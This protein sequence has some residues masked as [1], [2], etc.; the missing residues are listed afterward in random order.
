V[1]LLPDTRRVGRPVPRSL[2]GH[3]NYNA[4]SQFGGDGS[5]SPVNVDD[6]GYTTNTFGS[7]GSEPSYTNATYIAGHGV[8]QGSHPS[9]FIGT[10]LSNPQRRTSRS[11]LHEQPLSRLNTRALRRHH[12]AVRDRLRQSRTKLLRHRRRSRPSTGCNDQEHHNSQSLHRSLPGWP[13]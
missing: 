2:V 13:K 4:N 11:R 6:I 10:T 5:G 7:N 3:R 9:W 8:W 1:G 12:R